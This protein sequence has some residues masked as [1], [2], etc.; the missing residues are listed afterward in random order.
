MDFE[1]VDHPIQPST[2]DFAPGGAGAVVTFEGL[3]RNVNEGR[4]VV[5]LEYSA[6]PELALKEGEKILAE[7]RQRY[8]LEAVKAVHRV[9][10]LE[11]GDLAVWI[12]VASGHRGEALEACRWIIDEIKE[13]VPLWKKEIYA[14]GDSGWLRANPP[15]HTV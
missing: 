6:Y 13:R 4:P 3:V 14:D 15:R 7:A 12:A 5:A 10:R 11:I 2:R 9:G 8:P 1:I